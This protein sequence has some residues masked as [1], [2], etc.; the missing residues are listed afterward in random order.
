MLWR[1]L[2]R[3][4]GEELSRTRADGITN[5]DVILQAFAAAFN[6][7]LAR[8]FDARPIGD[9][10]A[11]LMQLLEAYAADQH[12]RLSRAWLKGD[13]L[14]EDQLKQ[15]NLAQS[16]TD[17]LEDDLA[18]YEAQQVV[19]AIT[20]IAAPLPVVFC[21]DQLEALGLSREGKLRLL[22]SNGSKPY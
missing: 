5:L 21:F 22:L 11:A 9:C 2:R 14:S 8:A 4:F 17:G 3:R 15:L 6:G 10:S 1:H 7:N 13:R 19:G 20:R 16:P 18:E 12:R